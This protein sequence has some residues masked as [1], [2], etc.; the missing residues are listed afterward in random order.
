MGGGRFMITRQRND[1]II[2]YSYLGML[3]FI[4]ITIVLMVPVYYLIISTFKTQADA[5]RFPLSPP[6]KWEFG[7]YVRAWVNMDYPN[8]FKNSFLI[9]SISLVGGI[10]ISSM[11]AFT[12]ARKQKQ[13]RIYSVLFYVFLAG[14]MVPMQM[15]I[16]AQYNLVQ[17]L[18]LMSNIF[19]VIFINIAGTLPMS[20]F[21][22]RNFII[23]SIPPQ[24]EEAALIDGCGVFRIF[25][26][27][28]LPLLRPVIVTLAVM[29]SIGLW[30]DFLTPLMFLQR[31]SSRTIMLAVNSNIGR[32]SVNWADMF[33]ML[34]LG[35]LPLVIFYLLM[36]KH[37]IKGI[38]AGSVKG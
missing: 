12:F 17:S 21:F 28:T 7:G 35:V 26:S 23:A 29:N 14:M 32:F 13:N 18:G 33:P 30:N 6:L 37:L 9:T 15:S 10:F 1:T 38:T 24:I 3:I 25:F 20:I 2:N 22:I 34:L 31:K 19:S 11:S 36:Q 27:I 5:V 4:F 16:M 8:A